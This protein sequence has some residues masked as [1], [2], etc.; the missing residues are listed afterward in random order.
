MTGRQVSGE[1]KGV[2]DCTV[3]LSDGEV[4]SLIN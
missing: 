4:E 2:G 3:L 1:S